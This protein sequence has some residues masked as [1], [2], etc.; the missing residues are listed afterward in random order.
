MAESAPVCVYVCVCKVEN[1]EIRAG[2]R[3]M[4]GRPQW[5]LSVV[6]YGL[7]S[8][9]RMNSSSLRRGHVW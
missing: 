4:S 5:S 1:E 8:R 7:S 3:V 2:V 6:F 9:S